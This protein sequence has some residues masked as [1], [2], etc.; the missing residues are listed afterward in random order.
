MYVYK[1]MYIYAD[2]QSCAVCSQQY[3]ILHPWATCYCMHSL[4]QDHAANLIHYT[5]YQVSNKWFWPWYTLQ[6]A[7]SK[8]LYKQTFSW[9]ICFFSFMNMFRL[10]GGFFLPTEKKNLIQ[11]APFPFHFSLVLPSCLCPPCVTSV[12]SLVHFSLQL[13]LLCIHQ[14]GNGQA[15]WLHLKRHTYQGALPLHLSF[16]LRLKHGPCQCTGWIYHSLSLPLFSCLALLSLLPCG[17]AGP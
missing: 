2:C 1:R 17:C 15:S 9:F 13:S 11:T 5:K 7:V 12:F 10:F 3:G 8:Y 6:T 4:K 14:D 16:S